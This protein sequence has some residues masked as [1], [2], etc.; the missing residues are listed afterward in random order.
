MHL[1]MSTRMTQT[2]QMVLA[3]RMIQSMEILQL[4]I[5]ALEE[6]IQQELQ[7]NP[8][9]E[10]KE[11]NE[12]GGPAEDAEVEG[13]VSQTAES[14]D[15]RDPGAAELVIDENSDNEVDFDRLEALSRDWDDHFNEEHRPSRNGM[16]EE[17]DKKHEAMNNMASRPQSLQDHLADQLPFLDLTSEQIDLCRFVIS[18][19]DRNGWMQIPLL[20]LAQSYEHSVT[21][22][23]VE[24]ALAVVQKLDPPGVGARDLTECLVLQLTPDTP[25]SDIL[26]VLILNHLDDIEHN[27]LPAV[28]GPATPA[29]EQSQVVALE[30][31]LFVDAFRCRSQ[32][33]TRTMRARKR[34][35]QAGQCLRA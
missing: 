2:Q 32:A 8:V 12:E 5:M 11:T 16:D 15:A 21:V 27:R 26:R 7:E 13:D 23:Q 30:R 3:P 9:L 31:A 18:H 29:A 24:E 1:N 35:C 25:H 14:D 6:R 33:S 34:T 10:L 28:Q 20:D 19:I 22:E 17:G 4:P